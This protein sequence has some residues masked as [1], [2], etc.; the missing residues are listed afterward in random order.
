MNKTVALGNVALLCGVM[1]MIRK[2]CSK[3]RAHLLFRVKRG[4]GKDKISSRDFFKVIDF[5]R[6][7]VGIK[8]LGIATLLACMLFVRTAC[9]LYMIKLMTT[10]EINIVSRKRTPAFRALVNFATFMLPLS[11][12][13][14]G[15]AYTQDSLRLT[16]RQSITN[17]LMNKF[18]SNNSFYH[19][20]N[21]CT[22][23]IAYC[24]GDD[25]N[26]TSSSSAGA[27]AR[28]PD[29]LLH[30]DHLLIHDVEDFAKMVSE[31]YAMVLKPMID[32]G[33]Y[34]SRLWQQFGGS[35]PAV[36]TI[37]LLT[38]GTLIN[39][40]RKPLAMFANGQQQLESEFHSITS[41]LV[42]H[43]EEIAFSQ[44]SK[45]EHEILGKSCDLIYS[46]LNSNPIISIFV[47]FLD[48]LLSY[49]VFIQTV[50]RCP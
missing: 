35:I 43:S 5:L 26:A 40:I 8:E 15:L 46:D 48:R 18:L 6:E 2:I 33:I 45:R 44:G 38:T 49:Y 11:V 42:A 36:M 31:L 30:P 23:G 29:I 50:S 14:A 7:C 21:H 12:V 27:I 41:R 17:H 28:S 32:I 39:S 4:K 20:S 25:P 34:T 19:V 13:N 37:Y 9:D 16:L 47:E 3:T 1:T 22:A 24:D 10:V